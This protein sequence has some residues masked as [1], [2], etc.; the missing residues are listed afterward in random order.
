[1]VKLSGQGSHGRLYPIDCTRRPVVP[2]PRTKEARFVPLFCVPDHDRLGALQP[3]AG[4]YQR[5]GVVAVPILAPN[6]RVLT[7]IWLP[8]DLDDV[9][10]ISMARAKKYPTAEFTTDFIGNMV[11][12]VEETDG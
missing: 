1:M 3:L 11:L 10:A 7:T 9:V 12:F 8:M 4:W 2:D 5:R 6:L